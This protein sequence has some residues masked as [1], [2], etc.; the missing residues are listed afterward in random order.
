MLLATF[1]RMGTRAIAIIIL[2]KGSQRDTWEEAA[3]LWGAIVLLN[4]RRKIE[5]HLSLILLLPRVQSRRS[6]EILRA[7]LI[8]LETAIS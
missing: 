3:V 4:F 5:F 8:W 7:M 1:R 2:A 6:S